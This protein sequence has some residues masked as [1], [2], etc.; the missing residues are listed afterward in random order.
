MAIAL[1][2]AIIAFGGAVLSRPLLPLALYLIVFF[3]FP[4][5][6]YGSLQAGSTAIYFRGSGQLF[7]PVLL[8]LLLLIVVWTA[9]GRAFQYARTPRP[10]ANVAILR[11]FFAW[12]VLLLLHLLWG[13]LAGHDVADVLGLH[14]F[15]TVPWMGLLVLMMIWAGTSE[16]AML[17]A[18]R[19]LVVT[20]L[21]KSWFGLFRFAFLGGDSANVY[22]NLM[23]IKIKLTYFDINDSLICLLG[24]AISLSLLTIH[25]EEN[26]SKIWR[27]LYV[28]TAV[29]A[30]L[31]IALS[32]RRTAWIGL[33]LAGIFLLLKMRRRARLTMILAGLPIILTGLALVASRRIGQTRGAHGLFAFFYDL[34]S[35]PFG[36]ESNRVLELRLAWEA[37]KTSP[38][39]GIGSW[40]RYASS[41]LIPWQD[42][43][44]GGSFLHSGVLHIAMKA[45]IPGLVL[46]AGVVAAFIVY[47]RRLP[48]DMPAIG[49]ALVLSGCSGLLFM[50]P[51]MLVGTPIPQLRTTQ[52]LAFCLG[53]PYFVGAVLALR[54]KASTPLVSSQFTDDA[55]LLIS[56]ATK[57]A[58]GAHF[59]K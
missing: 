6:N 18:G 44:S 55:R 38:L 35:R 2:T 22:Q 32:Y 24:L 16:R 17:V 10:D 53:L 54:E 28:V 7:F 8:W 21:L 36:P 5:S 34:S 19:L 47:V 45:G 48:L 58:A 26:V 52:L 39:V 12:F 40:G 25:R 20:A 56:P 4:T 50:L 29:S 33:M 27:A 30:V 31:C 57:R 11:W 46:L 51:D 37:F 49:L 15:V 3:I 41:D 14:G 1:A 23:G 9:I 43:A 13:V 42:P 59:A